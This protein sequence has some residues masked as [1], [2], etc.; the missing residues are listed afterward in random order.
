MGCG[1]GGLGASEQQLPQDWLSCPWPLSQI[2]L[3]K[4]RAMPEP[5]FCRDSRPLISWLGASPYWNPYTGAYSH[6]RLFVCVRWDLLEPRLTSNKPGS[7]GHLWFLILRFWVLALR[8]HA[9]KVLWAGDGTPGCACA[10]G[11]APYWAASE[12]SYKCLPSL[13]HGVSVFMVKPRLVWQG[14]LL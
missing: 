13:A 3:H 14:Y 11:H 2:C 12:P 4:H 7:W 9:T 1:L 8:S 5:S 10:K 6:L